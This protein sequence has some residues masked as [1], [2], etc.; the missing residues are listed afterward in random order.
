MTKRRNIYGLWALL[1]LCT[2]GVS[3]QATYDVIERRNFWNAGANPAGI[4]M[5]SVTIS[6]AELY[7]TYDSGGFR[8]S[9]QPSEGW[10]AGAVA[11][12]IT[13]TERYSMAGS[14]AFDHASGRDMAGS[15]FVRPG[16]YPVDILE[17]T[18]GRKIRQTYAFAGTVSVDISPN[19]RLGA[20]IDFKSANYAKRKDLR[21]TNYRLDLSIA[22]GVI[23]HRGDKAVG[24][25]YLF[26]KNSETIKAEKIG[27]TEL[28]SYMAFLDKGLMYGASEEWDGSGIHL[29]E[30]GI[31]GFPIKELS[32]GA[33]IHMQ[34]G[35]FF[36]DVAYLYSFGSAGEKRTIWFE[37]PTYR[38][39]SHLGYRFGKGN[40]EHFLRLNIDW[41][42]QV[43]NENVLG[44]ELSNGITIT[45][46]YGSNRIFEKDVFSLRAEYELVAPGDE[47]RVGAEVSSIDRLTT[48]MF[49]YIVTQSMV[50]GHAYISGVLHLGRLDLKA[51]VAFSKGNFDGKNKEIDTEMEPGDPPS[52]LAE[53]H[54]LQNE[55]MTAPR[56]TSDI[57]LR[58]RFWR[59]I[60]A[61]AGAVYT[62]GFNL[63]YIGGANRWHGT[64]KIGYTF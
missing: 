8:D 13:H 21:H 39:S 9:W 37:F 60:Y 41:S 29:S 57:A 19:W 49:P 4:R 16:H 6:N 10:S 45:H 20:G 18:P 15:M 33:A 22:P 58:Y 50:R 46:I 63:Q 23:Y 25:S 47:L 36:G 17:F 1:L 44:K 52:H 28:S 34:W 35:R 3:A 26:G 24:M 30:T 42:R 53:Y 62:H 11:R 7:G 14:F 51:G 59:E 55:Y 56:V 27:T 32:H 64:I 54:D 38:V 12:T 43:N 2:T 31:N 40:A 48:Q 5:D 61:E